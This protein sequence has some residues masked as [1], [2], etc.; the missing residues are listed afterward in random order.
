MTPD[1]RICAIVINEAQ[2]PFGLCHLE[3]STLLAVCGRGICS[4][5]LKVRN[6]SEFFYVFREDLR[7]VCVRS[8]SQVNH[9]QAAVV[10]QLEHGK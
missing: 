7:P 3:P 5:T 10:A 1:H 4:K 8:I 9:E 2:V 6:G